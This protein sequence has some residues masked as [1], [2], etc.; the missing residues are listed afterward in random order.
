MLSWAQP[1]PVPLTDEGPWK[2]PI[3]KG[4]CYIRYGQ[5]EDSRINSSVDKRTIPT[6]KVPMLS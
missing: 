5:N 4:H 2:L 1:L 3:K 6:Q